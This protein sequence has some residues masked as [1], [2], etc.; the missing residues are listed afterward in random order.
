MIESC[1]R[2]PCDRAQLRRP[3]R[4]GV[5]P[6]SLSGV[7]RGGPPM[8]ERLRGHSPRRSGASAGP[9]L[10]ARGLFQ[11]FAITFSGRCRKQGRPVVGRVALVQHLLEDV[12]GVRLGAAGSQRVPVIDPSKDDDLGFAVMAEKYSETSVAE[13]GSEPMFPSCGARE[14]TF[15][16]GLS[17]RKPSAQPQADTREAAGD[18]VSRSAGGAAPHPRQ[19]PHRRLKRSG[20]PRDDGHSA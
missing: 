18:A 1:A 8:S 2:L 12:I 16:G 11:P 13:L 15:H 4:I 6:R 20:T 7:G 19:R 14:R 5:K 9:A 3:L 17:A 10:P